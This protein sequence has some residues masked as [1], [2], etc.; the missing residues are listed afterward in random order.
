MT[1]PS[2]RGVR[3]ESRKNMKKGL[4]PKRPHWAPDHAVA[5]YELHVS[6][7]LLRPWLVLWDMLPFLSLTLYVY[8]SFDYLYRPISLWRY[9]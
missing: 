4:C 5:F 8:I 2:T 7:L 3:T 9:L 1:D 6:K